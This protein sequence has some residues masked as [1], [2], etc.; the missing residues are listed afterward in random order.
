MKAR[1]K[2]S[3]AAAALLF[4]LSWLFYRSGRGSTVPLGIAPFYRFCQSAL[5]PVVVPLAD[6]FWNGLSR[7]AVEA[8]GFVRKLYTGNGQTYLLHVLY[9][10]IAIYVAAI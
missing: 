6:G 2:S 9:Y 7:L 8:G 10:V 4:A 3:T 1:L 5:A